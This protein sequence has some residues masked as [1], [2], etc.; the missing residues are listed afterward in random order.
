[1]R[2]LPRVGREAVPSAFTSWTGPPW[3]PCG[4]TA[5]TWVASTTRAGAETSS[6]LPRRPANT[7]CV[8]AATREPS[9]GTVPP[10]RAASSA[11]QPMRQ[12]TVEA[13]ASGAEGTGADDPP[14]GVPPVDCLAAD[15]GAAQMALST[16]TT[17]VVRRFSSI[18]SPTDGPTGLADGLAASCRYQGVIPG[19][20]P[21]PD[22]PAQWF[23]RS[24]R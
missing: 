13:N 9:T 2:G 5:S 24:G 21:G 12:V 20:A 16:A 6:A 1:M 14:N 4:T 22:L 11:L 19:F 23:P 3:A 10:G 8:T 17:M 18:H 7:T 15:A